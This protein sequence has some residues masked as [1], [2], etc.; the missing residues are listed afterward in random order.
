MSE[1]NN[2]PSGPPE[3]PLT[4]RI[5]YDEVRK[6]VGLLEEKNLSIFELEIEGLKIKIARG[7]T[8]PV[9][10]APSPAVLAA[11]PAAS[12]QSPEATAAAEAQS[13]AAEAAMG[14]HLIASPMVG[15]FYRAPD[16]TSAPFVD[17]GDQVKKG[18]TLCIIEAM[19]LMNEIEADVDGTIVEIYVEN[20]KPVEFGQKLFAILPGS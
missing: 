5:D 15:T 16:P 1:K 8:A 18:Q 14:H 3:S 6:L 9:P 17:V 7:G 4:G 12:P 2:K 10:A 11:A 20:A 13:Q 19:K